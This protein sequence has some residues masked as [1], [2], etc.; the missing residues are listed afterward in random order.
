[1]TE[2]IN[3]AFT[4]YAGAVLQSRALPDVRDCFKPSARQIFYSMYQNKLI[5]S[6]PF[7]KTNNAIGLA[8]ADYYIHGDT[9]CEGIIMRASQDFAMRY[10]LVEV[11]GS[12]GDAK[13]TGNWSAPRYTSARLAEIFNH[14]I[15]DIDKDTIAEWR[16]NYDDT[17]QYPAILP[18]K[19][20]YNIVNGSLGIGV[21]AASSIPQFNIKEVNEALIKLLWNPDVDFEDI[22]CAPD[23]ATGAT[24][25][26]ESQ[27]KE[28][29]KNGTGAA[30]KLRSTV[31]W[32]P[33]DNCFVV[34][35]IPY[36]VYTST[37]RE[38]LNA[39]IE[40]EDNP[41]IERY[42]DLT[43]EKILLK[44]YLVK[45]ANPTKVLKS[46][47]KNTSL[48]SHYGINMTMLRDGRFPQVFGWKAAL[49]EHLKHEKLVYRCGFLYDLHEVEARIHILEGLLICLASID[50]VV[51]VIK[52]SASS[53]AARIELTKQFLLDDVQAKAVLDLK[54]A[55]LA[56]LEV[57]K[58][59][60]EKAELEKKRDELN[61]ILNNQNLFYKE[62]EKGFQKIS[63]LLG[64]ARRTKIMDITSDED[65]VVEEKQLSISFTNKGAVFV[66]ETS[67]LFT[68]RRGGV[69]AKF[70]L[71][72]DEFIVDNL[73]GQNTDTILFFNNKGNYYHTKLNAFAIGEKQYLSACGLTDNATAA[74]I[75]NP[76]QENRFIVFITRKGIIKKSKLSEYNLKRNTGAQAIKLDTG[77][78][79]TSIFT[80]IDEKI[81]IM[82]R[83]GQF[84]MINSS[85]INAI[86]RVTRGIM[87]MKLNPGDY[88]QSAR[89][90]PTAAKELFS[91]SEDGYGKLTRL[92]DFNITN[93]NTKGV[94]IQK[95]DK[96]SDFI[97]VTS[98]E[99]IL[100]NSTTTQIR[101]KYND[102]PL[103]LRDTLGVK[104]IK[105]TNNYV[106]GISTL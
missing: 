103:S 102:I 94:R 20:Y 90:I 17:K 59:E 55:R 14:I 37:I 32:D 85:T 18:S 76:K 38:E 72:S 93:T 96:M 3:T 6:K 100:I 101:I 74:V 35:E 30:C 11:E 86:G 9:S 57:E 46:L 73:I 48:Q 8:M 21:G 62:I 84:I 77:D 81:G 53:Q 88:V 13:M 99:D 16:D 91:I 36:N 56:H 71:D 52:S 106:V 40:S 44:I 51:Q 4:S 26:N 78:E 66:T 10:P 83:A 28:S 2:I 49:E 27:V 25:L 31:E 65:E 68:Q 47:Y 89:A 50:E 41:G 105:L 87:G 67:S 80:L 19:G 98:T 22:Y 64:D 63:K 5:H 97:P 45:K 29:L 75:L 61:A 33:K 7:K 82:S 1:M 60:K 79:I 39:L 95:S 54:L 43:G 69:G 92:S 42:N 24:L 12:N 23:F 70:K 58:L 34:T 104:L 15:E